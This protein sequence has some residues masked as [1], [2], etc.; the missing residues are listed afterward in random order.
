MQSMQSLGSEESGK[1]LRP[2]PCACDAS[3]CRSSIIFG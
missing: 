2:L 3:A 1:R